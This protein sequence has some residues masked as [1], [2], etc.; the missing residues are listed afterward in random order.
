MQEFYRKALVALILLLIADALIACFC[1]YQSYPSS[2]LMPRESGAARWH[3]A[4][5]TDVPFGGASTIRIDQSR[6]QSLGF[7]FKLSRALSYP[8]ASAALLMD[9]ADGR[10]APADLSKYSTVTFLAKCAPANTLILTITMFD[11]SVTK[12]GELLTYPPAMTFFSCNEKGV[13]VSLD[14]T[15]L[16]IPQWWYEAVK[17]DISRQSYKLDHVT[18]FEFGASQQSPRE[19]DSHVEISELKLHGRD[20]RYIAALA[21]ILVIGW[22][23]FGI[24]FF[25]G[26][27]RALVASLDSQMKK[28]LPFVAYRQLT[29]EPF[30]DKEKAAILRFLATNY[31]NSGLDLDSV[32]TGTGANRNKINEVLKTELG[33]TFTSYLNKLRLTEAARLLT[34]KAGATVAEI[35]YSVGY[36]NVSYFNKLFKEEY[37]CTPKAFRNLATQPEAPS[38]NDPPD[39]PTQSLDE[40]CQQ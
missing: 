3:F 4:P 37:G 15:R 18:K 13:P 17:V 5:F 12:P 25:R 23:A 20:Y 28:D 21:A 29:L 10:P 30:K 32:A 14:L 7:D 8:W 38:E 35:A 39:P 27:S 1:I 24:W 36:A 34:D 26:H 31:T 11:E 40:I 6:Q 19:L 2:S 9:D 16:T 33:M 22:S